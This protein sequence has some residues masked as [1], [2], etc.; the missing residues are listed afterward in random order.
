[1]Y[2]TFLALYLVHNT[3]ILNNVY[4]IVTSANYWYKRKTPLSALVYIS[5]EK[6]QTSLQVSGKF[7]SSV[8][9]VI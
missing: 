3:N 8:E 5:L 1:M 2:E 4:V 9:I 7:Q 6:M